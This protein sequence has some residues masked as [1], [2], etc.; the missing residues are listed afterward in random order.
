MVLVMVFLASRAGAYINSE[1]IAVDG[2]ARWSAGRL[3]K[4]EAKL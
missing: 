4:V 3:T 1:D 2:G